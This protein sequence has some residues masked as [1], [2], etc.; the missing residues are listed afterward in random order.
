MLLVLWESMDKAGCHRKDR[1]V[2]GT[3]VLL[4]SLHSFESYL[5]QRD[6]DLARGMNGTTVSTIHRGGRSYIQ[7]AFGMAKGN[8][9]WPFDEN[10]NGTTPSRIQRSALFYVV[11]KMPVHP[12]MWSLLK[13]FVR[14]YWDTNMNTALLEENIW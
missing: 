13:S 14:R 8:T 6:T 5:H 12:C 4:Y 2:S 3:Y 11:K 7:C 1:S 10:N 9:A